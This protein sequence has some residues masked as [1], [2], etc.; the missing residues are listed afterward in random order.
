MARFLLLALFA[1]SCLQSATADTETQAT[2]KRIQD[3]EARLERAETLIRQLME[4]KSS[5]DST[6]DRPAPVA[7]P[8]VVASQTPPPRET[9]PQELLPTLGL[10]GASASFVSGTHSGPYSTNPGTYFSG[11]VNLP[12]RKVPGGLLLYEFSAGLTRSSADLQVTSNVAQVANLAV[13][14]PSQLNDAL[15]GTGS[16][17]F[18]V[19][20]NTRSRVDLLQVVPFGFKY[21]SKLLDRWRI[22]P[23][24]NL[25]FGL[26]V[27][28]SNQTSLTGL[29]P[30]AN[31]PPALLTS[32]DALFG[33][34]APFG[35]ALIGGQIA[36][37]R[38]LTAMGIPSGQGGISPGFQSG[39]GF[40]WR[41]SP[42][43]SL[44][45]DFRRNRLAT[46]AAFTTVAPRTSFHF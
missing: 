36:A 24:A 16:A 38:E 29:R 11:S 27:T 46:G 40:E 26:F 5:L 19:T 12:L 2:L 39:G 37:S 34:G 32:L 3:L 25:G 45:L 44:G 31:L 6:F 18:P 41:L 42:R 17:P 13:L 14:G 21:Q 35:G 28:I 43:L 23:Y 8:E 10:I 4:Q 15:Q 9:M 20:V 33:N 30:E 1:T 7:A 22:R